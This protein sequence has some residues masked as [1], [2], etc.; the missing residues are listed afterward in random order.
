MTIEEAIRA[1]LKTLT[2][3][4]AITDVIRVD[5]LVMKEARDGAAAIVI[6]I[7]QELFD[8]TTAGVC[9]QV[10]AKIT[11]GCVSEDEA[12]ARQLALA[13]RKNG[14]DPGTGL[15]GCQVTSG[16]L[17]FQAMLERRWVSGVPLPDGRDSGLFCAYADYAVFYYETP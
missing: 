10:E 1:Y 9:E 17:P 4:A 8:N 12:V 15:A 14:T 2:A 6:G 5:R 13:V 7:D 3:V 11:I 16:S